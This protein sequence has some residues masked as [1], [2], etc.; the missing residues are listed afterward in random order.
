MVGFATSFVRERVWC[1][2]TY[3]VRPGLQGTGVG[4]RLLDAA[5]H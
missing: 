3:A 2:A 4:R 5:A 1:L